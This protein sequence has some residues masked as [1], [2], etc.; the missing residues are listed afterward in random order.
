MKQN[1]YPGWWANLAQDEAQLKPSEKASHHLPP[2]TAEALARQGNSNIDRVGH[3]LALGCLVEKFKAEISLELN[4]HELVPAGR[5]DVTTRDLCL[6]GEALRDQEIPDRAVK[7][8]F[9]W[10]S[11]E[12]T[13]SILARE[14]K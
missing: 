8:G 10:G 6:D 5:G 12:S 11:Q 7:G 4:Y 1:L 9:G 3:P 2:G 14:E 13:S